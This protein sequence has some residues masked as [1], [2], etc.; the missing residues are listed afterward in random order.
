MKIK[1]VKDAKNKEELQKKIKSLKFDLMIG[2]LTVCLGV[3]SMLAMLDMAIQNHNDK[4]SYVYS[5]FMLGA[6]IALHY[7]SLDASHRLHKLEDQL[8]EMEVQED[9]EEYTKTLTN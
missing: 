1:E 9:T 3:P 7:H 8:Y 6:L 2:R 4:F 5:I